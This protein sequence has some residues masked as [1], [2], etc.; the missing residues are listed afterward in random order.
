MQR[1][2]PLESGAHEIIFSE[3]IENMKIFIIFVIAKAFKIPAHEYAG[4][5]HLS[6]YYLPHNGAHRVGFLQ[7]WQGLY[8]NPAERG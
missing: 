3:N 7:K 2:D 6:F 4:I 8:L 1:G 5:Y